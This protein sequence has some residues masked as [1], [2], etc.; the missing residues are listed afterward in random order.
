MGAVEQFGPAWAPSSNALAIGQEAYTAGAAPVLAVSLDGRAARS[1]AA[2]GRGFDVPLGWSVDGRYLA[3]R[4]FSG[5]GSH[6]P[7]DESVVV[8]SR[9]GERRVVAARAEVLYLGWLAS[10]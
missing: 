8:I 2:P 10:G 1:L 7:G 5:E 6:A 3:A 9:D 4:S